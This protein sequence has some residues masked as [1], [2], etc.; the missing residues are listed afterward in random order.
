MDDP[1]LFD[2]EKA[3]CS[4]PRFDLSHLQE[5]EHV[6]VKHLLDDYKTI[7]ANNIFEL[8]PTLFREHSIN[9]GNAQAVKQLPRH[10]PN[11][12][13]AVVDPQVKE[14][15]DSNIVGPSQSP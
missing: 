7:F 11:T 8:G 13:K 15:T 9:T 2:N 10:L 14:M 1:F 6:C 12:L 4:E 3:T 5:N